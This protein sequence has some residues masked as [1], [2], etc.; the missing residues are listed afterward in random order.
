MGGSDEVD[1][2]VVDPLVLQH[3]LGGERRM[4]GGDP[5]QGGAHA[6]IVWPR[7]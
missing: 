4:R 7:T 2:A 6:P 5:E 1:A 3:E